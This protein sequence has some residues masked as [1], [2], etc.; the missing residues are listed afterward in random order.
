MKKVLVVCMIFYLIL[1][2][3]T[4]IFGSSDQEP[5]LIEADESIGSYASLSGI[6]SLGLYSPMRVGDTASGGS[7]WVNIN[8]QYN[9][10]RSYE[11]HRGVDLG[12]IKNGSVTNRSIFSVYDNGTVKGIGYN[13]SYGNYIIIENWYSEGGTT[14]KF[15]PFYCHLKDQPSNLPPQITYQTQIGVSGASGNASGIHLHMEIRTPYN[16]TYIR[17]YPPSLLYW[18]SNGTWGNN[19]SFINYSGT[20]GNTVTFRILDMNLGTSIDVPSSNVKIYYRQKGT[21]NWTSSSM[22]KSGSN[23]SFTFTGYPTGTL[24]EYFIEAKSGS[25]ED[26][27]A[28]YT[29]YRPYRYSY[30]GSGSQSD[31]PTDRPFVLVMNS[32]MLASSQETK[33]PNYCYPTV[34]WDPSTMK[35]DTPTNANPFVKEVNFVKCVLI[36]KWVDN[37]TMLA[38]VATERDTLGKPTAYGEEI[39]INTPGIDKGFEKITSGSICIVKGKII[40]EKPFTVYIPDTDFIRFYNED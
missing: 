23:F 29:A 12:S 35:K 6:N 40:S 27:H 1:C 32:Q 25:F 22:S 30:D 21:S 11:I 20:N 16:Y 15:T 28:Y 19:T 31:R 13:S 17:R 9:Q 36:E 14:Y 34:E 2:I 38:K 18:R 4:L 7:D 24:I 5:K 26:G 33:D 10:P 8:C 3:P 37:T 39:Y